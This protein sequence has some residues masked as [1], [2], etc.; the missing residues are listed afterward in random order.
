MMLQDEFDKNRKLTRSQYHWAIKFE[1]SDKDRIS[2]EKISKN[3]C[4]KNFKELWKE[5]RKIKSTKINYP[6]SVF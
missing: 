2:K 3:L 4:N 1:K 6:S 5:V